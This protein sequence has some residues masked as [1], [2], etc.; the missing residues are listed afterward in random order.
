MASTS[1]PDTHQPRLIIPGLAGF[2]DWIDPYTYP[3]M[4]FIVG[5]TSPVPIGFG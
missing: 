4:R 2:Y 1:A 5:A 3:L